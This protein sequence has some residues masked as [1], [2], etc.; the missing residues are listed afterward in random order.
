MLTGL[1]VDGVLYRFGKGVRKVAR[2]TFGIDISEDV[3]FVEEL[4]A[5]EVW[6][7]LWS[8]AGVQRVFYEGD[9]FP[10][11]AAFT[12]ALRRRSAIRILTAIP[13]NAHRTRLH[14][15]DD[16]GIVYDEVKFVDAP[17]DPGQTTGTNGRLHASKSAILPH[18][19]VYID[20]NASNCA[21]LAENTDARL[22]VL[23]D[24]SWNQDAD[25]VIAPY[26]QIKRIAAWDDILRE[27]DTLSS[28]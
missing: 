16:F 24:H 10:G 27:V 5:P 28:E 18:C 3:W 22:I 14:W 7:Y 21:E 8:D 26:P 23:V 19:D 1:D 9:A 17:K 4:V 12:R 13:E 20:D 15:L 25:A 2:D 6:A 11:A